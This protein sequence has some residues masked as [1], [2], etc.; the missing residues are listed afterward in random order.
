MLFFLF[1]CS[2]QKSAFV[3]QDIKAFIFGLDES[4]SLEIR[5]ELS[6]HVSWWL[7]AERIA[8]ACDFRESNASR[9][10]GSRS[11]VCTF[12]SRPGQCTCS[13]CSRS[14][15]GVFVRFTNN[16]SPCPV[17][18]HIKLS[19]MKLKRSFMFQ[20]ILATVSRFYSV[21]SWYRMR[22]CDNGE[23]THVEA[24][25]LMFVSYGNGDRGKA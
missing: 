23:I 13:T 22:W 1:A 21:S 8:L 14:C 17:P 16:P 18:R 6:S 3:H 25:R 7:N 15:Q 24:Y 12:L 9:P 10:S 19:I 2:F 4:N 20:W 11:T 5:V